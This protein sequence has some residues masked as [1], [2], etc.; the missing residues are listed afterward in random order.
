ML[1]IAVIIF[2]H[3][4]K[5]YPDGTVAVDDLSLE[6]HDGKIMILV[7]PSGPPGNA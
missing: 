1:G 6:V 3:P 7:G 5:H 4:T 2:E